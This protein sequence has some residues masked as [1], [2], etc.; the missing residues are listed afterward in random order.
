MSGNVAGVGKGSRG[1][2]MSDNV[3]ARVVRLENWSAVAREGCSDEQNQVSVR[4]TKGWSSRQGLD[5]RPRQS[6]IYRR[7]DL[8]CKGAVKR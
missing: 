2:T 7:S 6:A 3:T 5:G 1:K 4:W 8:E